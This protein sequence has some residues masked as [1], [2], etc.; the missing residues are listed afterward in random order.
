MFGR[1]MTET[2]LQNRMGAN[3][4]RAGAGAIIGLGNMIRKVRWSDKVD[5][6]E[7]WGVA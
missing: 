6:W 1:S 3:I 2:R 5:V 4:V 7:G